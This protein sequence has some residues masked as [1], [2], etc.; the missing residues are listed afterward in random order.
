MPFYLNPMLTIMASIIVDHR[1]GQEMTDLVR[2]NVS[3][4]DGVFRLDLSLTNQFTSR[5]VPL[6]EFRAV[7]IGAASGT[8]RAINADKTEGHERGRCG[9]GRLLSTMER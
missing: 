5:Y 4:A 9:S 3:L 8:V 1:G 6:V 2:S 7:A